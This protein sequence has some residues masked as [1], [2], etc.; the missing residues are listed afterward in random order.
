METKT[1]DYKAENEQLKKENAMLSAQV[2]LLTEQLLIMR[3]RQFG[4]SSEKTAQLLSD[5]QISLFNEAEHESNVTISEPELEQIT[6]KR[7]KQKGKREMDFSGL[8]VERIH[9]ELPEDKRVCPDCGGVLHACGHDVL[10]RELV[11]IPA[12]Y[13]I[14]EH[15]QTVY[16]CRECEESAIE[17]PMVKAEVPAPVI[18]GSGVAS[19]SLVAH[20]ANQKYTLAL[21]LYRQEQEFQRNDINLSRQT[22]ANWMVYTA[23]RWLK[24]IYEALKFGLRSRNVAHADETVV[25]VLREE[26]KTAKSE[27]RMWLYRTGCDTDRHIILYEYQP[28]RKHEN[29][30]IFLEG[31]SGYLHSDGY[32]A[33]HNLPPGIIVSACWAHVRRKFT[34]ILKSLPDYNR[35]GSPAMRGKEFCDRLFILERQ[36]AKLPT[37][38]HFKARYEARLQRSK[39]VM[40]EFFAWIPGVR[41]FSKSPLDKAKTYALNQRAWLENVLLDGRLE[42]SNNRAERSIK[43][44]VIGRKNWLFSNT[45]EG[46]TA[47]A[48]FYSI[49]ETAKENRLKPY[50]YMKFIFE[51]APNLCLANNPDSVYAL[52]PWNAPASCRNAQIDFNH[53]DPWDDI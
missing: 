2:K 1:A 34:D 45:K 12:Q 39:P 52:L 47:S 8:P 5:G 3:Q 7:T 29:P 18:R 41:A 9:H 44:F 33:Y 6:Y 37:N 11:V 17:T 15:V 50:E 49:I 22:M 51:I 30:R 26:G 13:K 14:T 23:E 16:A 43:P 53:Q 46:A 20:I 40:D 28:N 32:E 21:P 48:M 10:R 24:P 42:L 36:Y 38:N 25:K 31:F 19:P 35:S 27:S 4:S